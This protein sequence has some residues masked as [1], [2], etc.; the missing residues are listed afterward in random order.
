MKTLPMPTL[1]DDGLLPT[2]VRTVDWKV[3]PPELFTD[4]DEL[5][6]QYGLELVMYDYDGDDYVFAIR[7]Q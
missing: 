7:K 3:A 4:I 2:D 5:L 6:K 1:T